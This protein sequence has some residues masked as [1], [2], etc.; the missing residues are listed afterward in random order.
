MTDT[1][2]RI[3][4]AEDD[5]A[6]RTLLVDAFTDAGFHVLHAS[7]G[8]AALSLAQTE[9]PDLVL[10]DVKMPKKEGIEVLETLRADSPWGKAVPI[11][12]LTQLDSFTAIADAIAKHATGYFIKNE[13][14]I[15]EVVAA[16]SK[17]AVSAAGEH[18]RT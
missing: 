2:R 14:S 13:Q 17:H 4:I 5:E 15:E 3:L 6:F 10:L 11:F 1:P 8:E 7:D 9:H 18:N 12:V 16:V